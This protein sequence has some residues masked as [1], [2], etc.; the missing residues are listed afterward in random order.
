M[1]SRF[2]SPNGEF[3]VCYFGTS[4]DC[5]FLEVFS[6]TRAPRTGRLYIPR[7]SL[8]G[9]YAATARLLR[10][11]RLAYLADDG[12]AQLGIDQRIT[13]GD[14]YDLSQSWAQAIYGHASDLDGI[15]Y[16]ARHHNRLYSVAL[17]ERARGAIAFTS[18][19]ALGDRQVADLHVEIARIVNRFEI[20][21][22]D[23]R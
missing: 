15:F 23:E 22:L 12:L 5:C 1:S 7:T 19:G 20:D 3:G 18:W 10:P 21:L 16:A 6:T 2:D 9:Y 4:L 13:G 8:W 17:F 11:L 14:D